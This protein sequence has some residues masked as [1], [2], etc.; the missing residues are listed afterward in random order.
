MKSGI[1]S[2]VI[3]GLL[4]SAGFA[5]YAQTAAPDAART[6]AMGMHGHKDPAKREAMVTK[7][8]AELKSKLNIT[9]DQ[10]STWTNFTIAM[11]PTTRMDHQRPD[12]AEM[13]NLTT[14][15]RID[16]MRALRIQHMANRTAAMDKRFAAMK[17]L[18]AVLNADQKKT[19][20]A[21][22]A[23]MGRHHGERRGGH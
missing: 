11:K 13:E 3:A 22:H 19:F 7:R 20:D 1:P 10:E 16:K 9:A 14:P 2:L 18:Y 23:R 21:V 4:A 5:T 12:R 6:P 15:E 17:A 8:L